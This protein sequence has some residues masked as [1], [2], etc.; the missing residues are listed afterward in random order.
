MF[1]EYTEKDA[2][3]LAE[4][5]RTR[6]VSPAEL[7]EAAIEQIEAYNPRVNAVV[8]SLFER[9]RKQASGDLPEGPF[10]GVPF[11]IKDL[12]SDLAG[13]P[14]HCGSHMYRGYRP[15][16]NSE[17]VDRYLASGAVIVGKTN[18]PELGLMPTTEADVYGPARNPWNPQLT[19][20][21]SSGGSGAAVALRMVPM[22]GGGDGGGSIRIPGSACGLF[23]LKPTRGRNPTV[24][25]EADNWHG[26]AVEH[27]LTRSVRD[28]ATMLD[29]VCG[30]NLGDVYYLPKPEVEYAA[31]ATKEPRSLRIAYSTEPLLPSD[32]VHPDCVAAIH[33]TV[34]LLRDLGHEVVQD[35]PSL[36]SGAFARAFLVVIS[37]HTAAG[38]RLAE[39]RMGR[40]ANREDFEQRTWLTARM[41]EA[42]TAGE[43]VTAVDT[44]QLFGRQV[45]EFASNYDVLL[46]PTLAQPPQP[47]GFLDPHGIK[48]AMEHV[49][50]RLPVG[51][52][53]KNTPVFEQA[54]AEV[55]S[56]I[57]WT[58]VYNV[59]GQPSMSVPLYWNAENLPVG[60]M[61]TGAFGDEATLFRL[62][63]QLE[64]AR[65]WADRKPPML[66]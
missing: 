54:A 10:T 48:A 42:F 27:V 57:P 59:T 44:V 11:L 60:S 30:P 4:L 41:G 26:Y 13:E 20:G 61:F 21:G 16:Q 47:L 33:D 6:Q 55:F 65:P 1:A 14:L 31:E 51:R 28:S 62:A 43:Y 63:G 9:A 52:L 25:R 58:P 39:E 49:L 35:A 64:R 23:G 7:V 24:F 45:L 8:Y 50:L 32:H 40:K 37:C 66:R 15:S 12:L 22:A 34:T 18:T 29:A 17:L 5:V 2:V 38:I 53:V 19:T 46:N 3:G 56:F 36:D